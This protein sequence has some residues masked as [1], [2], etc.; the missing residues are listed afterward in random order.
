MQ[1]LGSLWR[2]AV[3]VSLFG[4]ISAAGCTS[5]LFNQIDS[6]SGWRTEDL[7]EWVRQD[8]SRDKLIVFVHGFNSSKGTA[9]EEFPAL[10]LKDDDF[11]EFNIQLFGY[12]TDLCRSTD[13][14][15]K[16]G[17]LLASF[18]TSQFKSTQP[19]YRQ[20]SLVGHSMGGLV[21]LHALVKL[22]R[23]NV[24]LLRDQ[25]VKVLTFGTPYYGVENTVLAPCKSL[26]VEDMTVLND[27]LGDLAKE[28]DQRFNKNIAG[29]R[30]DT[31]Q[32]PVYAFY[33]TKDRFIS[34]T[35]ACGYSQ[36][37]C[38][39]VD[40]DHYSIVKPRNRD[41]LAY[42][43]LSD[44][45]RTPKVPATPENKIGIWI[46]RL[47]GDDGTHSAQRDL[48]RRLEDYIP[49]EEPELQ[50]L[51]EIRE[52]PADVVGNTI[53]EKEIEAKRLGT[54]YHASIVI[55]GD[56]T[57]PY[58]HPRIKLVKPD[59][60]RTKTILLP[61][62]EIY[63]TSQMTTLP[64][65][66]TA[67]SQKLK[68]PLQMA[69]FVFALIS[70]NQR[71][72]TTAAR[73]LDKLMTEGFK[74]GVR[75]ADIDLAAGFANLNIYLTSGS[76]QLLDN[77]RGKYESALDS[78]K[79]DDD[80]PNYLI[81]Q[82]DLGL[83][84]L[85]YADR[86]MDSKKHFPLAASTL[87]DVASRHMELQNWDGYAKAR[88][89]L[90]LVYMLSAVQ[91]VTPKDN[92]Q[93]ALYALSDAA[94]QFNDQQNWEDYA[95]VQVNLGSTFRLLAEYGLGPK[96][97]T[98]SASAPGENLKKSEEALLDATNRYTELQN[99]NGYAMAQNNLGLTYQSFAQHQMDP[100]RNLMKAEEAILNAAFTYK[101]EQNLA[102]YA[103]TQMNIGINYTLLAQQNLQ[104]RENLQTAMDIL[105]KVAQR[106]KEQENWPA[107]A[108][109]QMVLGVTYR[110]LL[111]INN[112]PETNLKKAIKS[113]QDASA[114]FKAQEH[115]SGYAA[116]QA[117]LAESYQLLASRGVSP[118]ANRQK[119]I[120]ALCE[121]ARVSKD[122]DNLLMYDRIRENLRFILW[123]HGYSRS[124]VMP[125]V[126]L[127]HSVES[128][129]H[130]ELPRAG[131]QN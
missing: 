131:A 36:T 74:S 31:P 126:N 89:N 42:Q 102:N 43:K 98:L 54:I 9:W 28:W 109:A 59:H 2:L 97:D 58:F 30:K 82:N 104:P 39:S 70:L 21:I 76:I 27:A 48:A 66:V 62:S 86:G 26:Q 63:Q 68:S 24:Q 118:K 111:L 16:Q 93:K 113:L 128:L 46:A 125:I 11:K 64:E 65:N 4:L 38:E 90:G 101:E 57:G 130:A 122:Q 112:D 94:L 73:Q 117:S 44:L 114:R 32:I 29:D 53:E 72:W 5:T 14:I 7:R 60:L 47:T 77:A 50:G 108:K 81:A 1:C 91:G 55:W 41:H 123:Y 34:K 33:G 6:L 95:I 116:A 92:L 127:L 115:W 71:H 120:D 8:A 37:L 106:H 87:S 10:L 88:S 56:V 20:V 75:T 49:R 12:P 45:V 85:F 79:Q 107:Y 129:C 96:D 61:G 110:A 51:V 23:D 100:V 19:K 83:I 99:W 35:S 105:L 69:R 67:P 124:T 17:E 103:L 52:L 18:L 22:E 25:D 84:Y 78:Y 13:S 80:S 15:R 40:G 119:S 3:A 121:A